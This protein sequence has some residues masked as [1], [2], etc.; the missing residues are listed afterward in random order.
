MDCL[1]L[2]SQLDLFIS[3]SSYGGKRYF[4]LTLGGFSLV[5]ANR[6]M[7]PLAFLKILLTDLMVLIITICFVKSFLISVHLIVCDERQ[8]C[9]ERRY[10]SCR[11]CVRKLRT[12]CGGDVSAVLCSNKAINHICC[13]Q[14]TCSTCCNTSHSVCPKTAQQMQRTRV[15]SKMSQSGVWCMCA[16]ILRNHTCVSRVRLEM[17]KSLFRRRSWKHFSLSDTETLTPV[18][19]SPPPR[20]ARVVQN[21]RQG[22]IRKFWDSTHKNPTSSILVLISSVPG[23]PILTTHA[24]AVCTEFHFGTRTFSRCGTCETWWGR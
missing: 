23:S 1:L 4:S 3:R 17:E 8:V 2:P 5:K 6:E 10:L 22:A 18:F 19:L 24:S 16:L 21:R 9:P 20:K 7:S 12:L 15:K 14:Q 13:L 11:M